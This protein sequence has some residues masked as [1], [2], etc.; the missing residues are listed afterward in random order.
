MKHSSGDPIT[1]G[2]VRAFSGHAMVFY[3]ACVVMMISAR[4]REKKN[5]A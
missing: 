4:N 5:R 3:T 1:A 2:N